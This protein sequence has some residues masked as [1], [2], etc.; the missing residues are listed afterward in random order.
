MSASVSCS[1]IS[2]GTRY[3]PV[4]VISSLLFIA[5]EGGVVILGISV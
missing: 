5:L 1:V 2:T 4:N 3:Q